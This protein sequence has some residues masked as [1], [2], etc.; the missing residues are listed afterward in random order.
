MLLET[1]VDLLS[2]NT[3]NRMK[4]HHD[5][6]HM[7]RALQLAQGGLYSADP[8]PRVGCVLVKDGLIIGEGWH[9]RAGEAHAEIMAIQSALGTTKGATA[10]VTLE[11]CCHTGRTGPC[12]QA[13]IKAGVSRIVVA[14]QDPNPLVAGQGLA[15]LKEAGI[16]VESG[17]MELQAAGLNPGFIKRMRTGRPYV[18]SKLAMSLDGR[19]AM[20]SGESK[21][22]TG[23]AAR[24]DVQ[25]LR[26]RSSA[27]VTGIG[28]VL[29]D[30][31]SLNVRLS[32]EELGM[33]GNVRQPTRVVLDA[34][35]SMMPG[36]KMLSLMGETLVLT[37]EKNLRAAAE[38]E[39]AG[40]E[41]VA[42]PAQRDNLDLDAVLDLLGQRGFNEVLLETGAR[43]SGAMLRAGLIDEMVIYLAPHLM[44]DA[45]RGL[46]HLPGLDGMRDRIDLRI[47]D[48]R[49]IGSDWRIRAKVES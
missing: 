23:E 34:H 5:Q 25:K 37:E 43:L 13:L 4:N 35:L 1:Y 8:N 41:I 40:A 11:P 9:A 14:M 44:G 32:A 2:R 22:I 48:I 16:A 27:I 20:E 30:D 3:E 6:I 38:L 31:P 18:R 10:Y 21:W 15:E 47:E 45:A 33:E 39:A 26:A 28:T 17:L 46:F 7:S 49:A 12:T 29:S 19:T 36:A 24:R 42:I